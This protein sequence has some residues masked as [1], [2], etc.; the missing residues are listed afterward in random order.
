LPFLIILY[1]CNVI[2]SDT[3][4]VC[5]SYFT[6]LRSGSAFGM[7][8]RIQEQIECGAVSEEHAANK[9]FISKHISARR[10]PM[11]NMNAAWQHDRFPGGGRPALTTSGY[12]P[13]YGN[14]IPAG[15]E[16]FK[17]LNLFRNNIRY[18]HSSCSYFYRTPTTVSG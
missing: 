9:Y 10:E 15:P 18:S 8:N 11:R 12:F 13:F 6:P 7:R 4:P 16:K 14:K 17:C 2:V 1:Y 3:G 5:F